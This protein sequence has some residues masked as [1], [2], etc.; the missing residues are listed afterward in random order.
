MYADFF[1]ISIKS[2]HIFH[3]RSAE[4]GMISILPTIRPLVYGMSNAL[5]LFEFLQRDLKVII[6]QRV[7]EERER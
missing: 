3:F 2:K 7:D 1:E 5:E 4:D 6:Q